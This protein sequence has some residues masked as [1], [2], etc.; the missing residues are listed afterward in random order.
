MRLLALLLLLSPASQDPGDRL[1]FDFEQTG[2][3]GRWTNLEIADPA[4]ADKRIQKEP[5]VRV[6]LSPEHATSGGKSLKLTF[7]GGR[8]PT[9][10]TSLPGEDWMGYHRLKADVTVTRPCLVGFTVLQEKS[11]RKEGWEPVVGRW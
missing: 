3:A 4:Q 9:V 7:A 5:P 6:E 11:S 1:L 2:E 8:W 10:A